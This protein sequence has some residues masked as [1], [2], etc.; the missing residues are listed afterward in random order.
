MSKKGRKQLAYGMQDRKTGEINRV[1][2]SRAQARDCHRIKP[3]WKKTEKIVV[4]ELRVL[5]KKA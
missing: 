1:Y 5:A 3:E 4:V 2:M